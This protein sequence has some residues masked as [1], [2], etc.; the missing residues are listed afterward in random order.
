MNLAVKLGRSLQ[1]DMQ[2]ELRE[3]ERAVVAGTRDT[4]RGLRTGLAT[5][6]DHWRAAGAL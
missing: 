3:V 5:A 4:G 2:A 1:T 6:G